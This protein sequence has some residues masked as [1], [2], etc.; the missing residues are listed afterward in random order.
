MTGYGTENCAVI[1]VSGLLSIWEFCSVIKHVLKH[2]QRLVTCSNCLDQPSSSSWSHSGACRGSRPGES[3]RFSVHEQNL[4]PGPAVLDH[5]GDI[6][7]HSERDVHGDDA[8][9]TP[10]EK[11]QIKTT[12]PRRVSAENQLSR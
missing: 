9:G 5:F 10:L 3:H 11:E 6:L 7:L 2:K 1:N 12:T 4:H 8:V